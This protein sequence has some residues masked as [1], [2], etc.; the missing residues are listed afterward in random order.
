MNVPLESIYLKAKVLLEAVLDSPP[1]QILQELMDAPPLERI[2]AAAE[3]LIDLGA[4]DA[5]SSKNPMCFVILIRI[6]THCAFEMMLFFRF[7]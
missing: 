1:E 6:K 4:I 2:R 3:N 7:Y 5:H